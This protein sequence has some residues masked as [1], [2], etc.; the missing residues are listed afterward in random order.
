MVLGPATGSEDSGCLMLSVKQPLNLAFGI[1]SA[2]ASEN[3]SCGSWSE[4]P[5][6]QRLNRT[7]TTDK[8]FHANLEKKMINEMSLCVAADPHQPQMIINSQYGPKRTEHLCIQLSIHNWLRSAW[9]AVLTQCPVIP[10]SSYL[11]PCID[12]YIYIQVCSG[13]GSYLTLLK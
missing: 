7:Y 11:C 5:K 3:S 4:Y 10:A 9:Q 8:L 13:S 1:L 2:L 6:G 12:I